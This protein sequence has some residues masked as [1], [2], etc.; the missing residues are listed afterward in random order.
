MKI[1]Y[2]QMMK[3]AQKMQE[4]MSKAQED[5]KKETIEVTYGGGA[6]K[7][8]ASG[9]G[10]I[11]GI[12]INPEVVDSGDTEMLQDMIL[13]AVNDAIEKARTL[14]EQKMQ[15]ITGGLGIPGM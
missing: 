14:Q 5:L 11:T 2:N 8:T 10:E 7:V 3:Q 4:D 13:V 9:Y 1:D 12:A 15:S 6:V